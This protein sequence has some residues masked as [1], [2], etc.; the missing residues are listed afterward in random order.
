[1]RKDTEFYNKISHRYSADRY[2]VVVWSYTQFFFK[3]RLS[4]V[5]DS[6]GRLIKETDKDLSVLEIGCADGVVLRKIYEIF[7]PHF[8][9]FLGIDISPKMIEVASRENSGTGIIFKTRGEYR[10]TRQYDLIV[11]VGVINYVASLEN[12]IAYVHGVLKG[13]G[14]YICSVAGTNSL[15]NKIE[16]ADKGFSNFCSYEEYEQILQNFFLIEKKI[17]VGFF[18]PLLWRAPAVARIVQPIIEIIF[19][20]FVPNLFHEN[21]YLLKKKS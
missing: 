9:Y 11:E 20:P 6:I 16:T 3:R 12:E 5:V 14:Y 18:M 10:D 13:S 2:P 19:K 8:F 1:M 4:F 7:S 17:P 21:V 15:W